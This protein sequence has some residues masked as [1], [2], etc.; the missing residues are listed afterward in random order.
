MPRRERSPVH[1][2]LHLPA[3]VRMALF[4]SRGEKD[5]AVPAAGAEVEGRVVL[6]E[7][8]HPQDHHRPERGHLLAQVH[9]QQLARLLYSRPLLVQVHELGHVH[10]GH[11]RHGAD[12]AGGRQAQRLAGDGDDQRGEVAEVAAVVGRD[13]LLQN[14][15]NGV[16]GRGGNPKQRGARVHNGTAALLAAD[17]GLRDLA[18]VRVDRGGDLHGQGIQLD[19]PGDVSRHR[20]LD[21]A[22]LALT[23]LVVPNH[24]SRHSWLPAEAMGE[25]LHTKALEQG[26]VRESILQFL[27]GLLLGRCDV[28][29]NEPLRRLHL[30]LQCL[31]LLDG[32]PGNELRL[33]GRTD[34]N[35]GLEAGLRQQLHPAVHRE[36]HG[37][38][39]RLVAAHG[40]LV[41]GLFGLAAAAAVG[42]HLHVRPAFEC[43]APL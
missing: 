9:E 14:I 21:N 36:P 13:V 19:S 3:Q 12:V 20:D 31:H 11:P 39:G 5:A 35:D 24:P 38:L 16:V 42:E 30:H 4:I 41:G 37:L 17:E 34:A 2:V 43:G 29:G 27:L 6:A 10:V 8:G 22:R 7:E 23:R 40:D 1:A 25:G 28:A 15:C 26:R 32:L 33:A 18:H